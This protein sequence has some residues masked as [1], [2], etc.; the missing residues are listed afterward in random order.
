M[1]DMVHA[2]TTTSRSKSDSRLGSV[3][4]EMHYLGGFERPTF[5]K[6]VNIIPIYAAKRES[7]PIGHLDPNENNV[8]TALHYHRDV[9]LNW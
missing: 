4:L 1:G 7:T 9:M 6:G 5:P 8:E 3:E 2:K